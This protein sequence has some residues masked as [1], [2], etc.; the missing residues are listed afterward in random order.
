VTGQGWDVY[1]QDNEV[2]VIPRGDAID[3]PLTDEC[4]CGPRNEVVQR[5]DGSFGWLAVHNSVDGR[6]FSEPDH[7]GAPMPQEQP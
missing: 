2:H 4:I 1:T 6:E 7:A 5:D 3:H